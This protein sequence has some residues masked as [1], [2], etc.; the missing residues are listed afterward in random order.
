[1]LYD[2]ALVADRRGDYTA[3][4]EGYLRCLRGD[5]R[6]FE[7]RYNLV[8]LTFRAGARDEARH[9]L[10]KL[11]ELSPGDPRVTTLAA[12]IGAPG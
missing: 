6:R 1:V 3:A 4:R 8:V 2:L 9:H 12:S 10:E 11:R 7:A 5:P